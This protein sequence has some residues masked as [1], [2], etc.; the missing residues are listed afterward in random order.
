MFISSL[1]DFI[2]DHIIS[3]FLQL[4]PLYA[5]YFGSWGIGWSNWEG[6]EITETTSLEQEASVS[7]AGTLAARLI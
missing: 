5:L 6:T 4:K 1:R 7:Y 3:K 2:G